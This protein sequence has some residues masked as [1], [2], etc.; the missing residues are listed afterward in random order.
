MPAYAF[1]AFN[2]T[3]VTNALAVFVDP[4][5]QD[6]IYTDQ[7]R[8]RRSHRL[9]LPRYRLHGLS[10]SL[11]FPLYPRPHSFAPAA[12]ILCSARHVSIKPRTRSHCSRVFLACGQSIRLI[13]IALHLHTN[14]NIRAGDL[15]RSLLSCPAPPVFWPCHTSSFDLVLQP[16]FRRR[17]RTIRGN[18]RSAG[19]DTAFTAFQ[20]SCNTTFSHTTHVSVKIAISTAQRRMVNT[21]IDRQL[22]SWLS[23]QSAL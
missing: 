5:L 7:H 18:V 8:V 19:A 22:E 4:V 21:R 9:T 10:S 11:T 12:H 20:H 23:A 2:A 14:L 15:Q 16:S 6:I 13:S 1:D 17:R 3:N